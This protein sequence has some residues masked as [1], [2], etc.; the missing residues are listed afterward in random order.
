M[1]EVDEHGNAYV[2]MLFPNET[3]KLIMESPPQEG[4]CARIRVYQANIKKAVVDRDTDLLTPA[5]YES[6]AKD[7]QSAILE[8][9][10]IWIEHGCF[11]RRVRRGSR[12]I[13][14]VRWIG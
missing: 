9:L 8:E 10:T 5:E 1:I 4:E 6:K 12:N 3:A 13:L 7:V 11:T 14:D 2:E